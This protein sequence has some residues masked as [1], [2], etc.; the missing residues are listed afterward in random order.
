MKVQGFEVQL[1]IFYLKN[2]VAWILFLF[3][4]KVEEKKVM[5]IDHSRKVSMDQVGCIILLFSMI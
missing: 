4:K 3:Q 5:P 1:E 2:G